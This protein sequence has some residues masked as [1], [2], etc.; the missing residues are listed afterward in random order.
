MTVSRSIHVST[1]DPVLF[2]F[3]AGNKLSLGS[4]RVRHDW[5]DL[6]AAAAA[7]I[8]LCIYVPHLLHPFFYWCTFRLLPCPGYCKSLHVVFTKQ[9]Q[10]QQLRIGLQVSTV[11]G[12]SLILV[13][14]LR[15]Q[16]PRRRGLR[17][18]CVERHHHSEKFTCRGVGL[19]LSPLLAWSVPTSILT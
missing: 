18:F 17:R 19:P 1:N 5:S 12:L 4:H 13:R 6:A 3:M 9:Q 16:K 14:E 15:S 8:F 7:A 2:L 10:Q 11:E